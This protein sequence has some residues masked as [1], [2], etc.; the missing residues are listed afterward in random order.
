M[1][2]FLTGPCVIVLHQAN[3][4]FGAKG[5]SGAIPD[6][7]TCIARTFWAEVLRSRQH[8]RISLHEYSKP[9]WT[10]HAKGLWYHLPDQPLPVMTLVGSP[11]FGM[12][13]VLHVFIQV[14][15]RKWRFELNVF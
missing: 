1:L 3:G 8:D 12:S 15:R 10:V 14:V 7:Y 11:N 5:V 6:A 13:I 9:G 2:F 4:F